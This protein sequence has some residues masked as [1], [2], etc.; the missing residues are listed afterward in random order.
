M[1]KVFIL[2]HG[3]AGDER[4]F[5]INKE[6]LVPNLIEESLVAQRIV[7]DNVH[8]QGGVLKTVTDKKMILA[9]RNSR[10]KYEKALEERRNKKHLNEEHENEKKSVIEIE[11]KKKKK[12]SGRKLHGKDKSIRK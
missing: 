12:R 1:Q 4:G 10:Q 11:R 6:Y 9:V 2:S 5:S 3:N 8:D 7:Y